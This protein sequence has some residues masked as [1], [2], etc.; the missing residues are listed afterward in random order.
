MQFFWCCYIADVVAPI[1]VGVALFTV[2]VTLMV[3]MVVDSGV[4]DVVVVVDIAQFD[5]ILVVIAFVVVLQ[6]W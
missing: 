5:G 3:V 6:I 4:I 2:G 1:Y